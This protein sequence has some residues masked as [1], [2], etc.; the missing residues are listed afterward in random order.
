MDGC[1]TDLE[2]QGRFRAFFVAPKFKPFPACILLLHDIFGVDHNVRNYA[3][4]LA[5]H[6]FPVC[7]PDLYWRL[8]PGIQLSETYDDWRVALRLQDEFDVQIGLADARQAL[9]FF[10]REN[11]QPAGLV[12]GYGL[13][14][15]IATLLAAD[16]EPR[17]VVAY[18]GT[19]LDLWPELVERGRRPFMFHVGESDYVLD[20]KKRARIGELLA[21]NPAAKLYLYPSAGH[22]FVSP[23]GPTYNRAASELADARTIEFFAR[24]SAPIEAPFFG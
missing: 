18:Y 7:C 17:A 1:W 10:C 3:V 4:N 15:L 22:R 5:Q 6:G 2:P 11:A 23:D 16:A 13:G 19:G 8:R 24:A 14:G 20:D 9:E 21:H 12:V